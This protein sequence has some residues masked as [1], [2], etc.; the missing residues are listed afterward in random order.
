MLLV[1][2]LLIAGLAAQNTENFEDLSARAA[3]AR[4]AND[5]PQAVQLYRQA[6]GVRPRWEEGWWFLGSMLYDSDRYAE[7]RDAL[8]HVVELDP[9]AAAAWALL[10]LCEFET[11]D[12]APS[13]EHIR[14]SLGAGSPAPQ[15]EE[16]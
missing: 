6:V 13:L 11:G 14:R 2:A 7:G 8:A 1:T 3:A 15:M 12:Y 5:I 4:E 10:G 9:R 16:V